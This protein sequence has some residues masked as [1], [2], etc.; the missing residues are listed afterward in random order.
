M[1]PPLFQLVRTPVIPNALRTSALSLLADCVNTYAFAVLAYVEELAA[2]MVDLVQI[3]SV[4]IQQPVKKSKGN[5]EAEEYQDPQKDVEMKFSMADDNGANA[6]AVENDAKEHSETMDTSP[7]S[8]NPKFPPLRRA[9]L[10]FLGLLIKEAVRHS[11]ES[12]IQKDIFLS[13]SLVSRATVVLGYIASTD[14]DNVVR[15]MAREVKEG[16]DDLRKA[17]LGL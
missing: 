14:E 6:K 5:P 15:F 13:N 4:P 9:A 8:A 11:Y 2:A 17:L 7:T 1:V 3:E 12:P 10:Y 16:L